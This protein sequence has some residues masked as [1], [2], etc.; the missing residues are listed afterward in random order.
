MVINGSDH[1]NLVQVYPIQRLNKNNNKQLASKEWA[2]QFNVFMV[3]HAWEI[4]N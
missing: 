3:V 4:P 1:S 2:A